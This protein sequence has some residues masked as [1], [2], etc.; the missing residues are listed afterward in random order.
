MS[1]EDIASSMPPETA[2][3]TKD[4]DNKIFSP[5]PITYTPIKMQVHEPDTK[6]HAQIIENS[7][8]TNVIIVPSKEDFV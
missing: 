1:S 7:K 8:V 3:M 2:Y 6:L 5:Q 4:A